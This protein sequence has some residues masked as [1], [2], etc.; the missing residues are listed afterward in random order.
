MNASRK[1]NFWP[2]IA[3]TIVLAVLGL[4]LAGVTNCHGQQPQP[5]PYQGAPVFPILH[6]ALP[7]YDGYPVRNWWRVQIFG[8]PPL[9]AQPQ[10]LAPVQPY[11]PPLGVTP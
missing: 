1:T 2:L 5:S 6:R 4:M 9:G 3:A 10:P 7:H 11:T 8:L